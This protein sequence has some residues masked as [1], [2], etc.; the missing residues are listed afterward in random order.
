MTENEQHVCAKCG[1]PLR[2]P[3][4]LVEYALV[5]K[6]RSIRGSSRIFQ[7]VCEEHGTVFAERLSGH[8]STAV[9]SATKRRFRELFPKGLKEQLVASKQWKKF[10]LA[11]GGWYHPSDVET[12]EW[13]DAVDDSQDS[14]MT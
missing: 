9:A 4:S 1:A 8:H 2:N 13:E 14:P 12:T 10:K 11:W 6:D 7:G 5:A 3:K